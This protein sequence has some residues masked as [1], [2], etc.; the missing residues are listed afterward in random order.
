MDSPSLQKTPGDGNSARTKVQWTYGKKRGRPLV[1]KKAEWTETQRIEDSG[2][3]KAKKKPSEPKTSLFSGGDKDIYDL[4]ESYDNEEVVA[5]KPKKKRVARKKLPITTIDLTSDGDDEPKK[6][7]PQKPPP[8]KPSPQKYPQKP[9]P[10]KYSPPLTRGQKTKQEQRARS[11]SMP[12][13]I[14]CPF[15]WFKGVPKAKFYEVQPFEDHA[16]ENHREVDRG[17]LQYKQC[18]SRIKRLDYDKDLHE[19]LMAVARQERDEK[20][21]RKWLKRGKEWNKQERKSRYVTPPT[22]GP[23]PVAATATA[24]VSLPTPDE[25]PQPQPF[26]IFTKPVCYEPPEAPVGDGMKRNGKEAMIPSYKTLTDGRMASNDSES[27]DSDAGNSD[28]DKVRAPGPA[29]GA[30]KG[31]FTNISRDS[32]NPQQAIPR[33][34]DQRPRANRSSG[35]KTPSNRLRLAAVVIHCSPK[36]TSTNL[37]ATDDA[38]DNSD[39]E[40]HSPARSSPKN[41]N[42]RTSTPSKLQATELSPGDTDVSGNGNLP[43]LK[44][45]FSPREPGD[46]HHKRPKPK[47]AVKHSNRKRK[48]EKERVVNAGM[49]RARGVAAKGDSDTE[50]QGVGGHK[51]KDYIPFP[52]EEFSKCSEGDGCFDSPDCDDGGGASTGEEGSDGNSQ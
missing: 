29:K 1:S 3:E 12:K 42:S 26:T 36:R 32:R 45:I 30:P 2:D 51:E 10:Q 43:F 46:A 21:L 13:P 22:K 28:L 8:Q 7:S 33:S 16:K 34:T 52:V 6:P 27:P 47:S 44:E 37:N 41:T 19:A 20:E 39:S 31:A 15:C 40:D 50:M 24:Q 38:N 4:P 23:L 49:K 11:N 5:S 48:S 14:E 25:T 9:S 18:K 35:P 17:S